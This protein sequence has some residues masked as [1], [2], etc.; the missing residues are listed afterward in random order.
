M[1]NDQKEVNEEKEDMVSVHS[2]KNKEDENCNTARK[3]ADLEEVLVLKENTIDELRKA[4]SNH[5]IE[6]DTLIKQVE[7][8]KQ[9]AT[10][11]YKELKE[12]K[13]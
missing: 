8:I 13:H 10:N 9:I 5:I 11:I 3:I 6:K 12:L 1:E 2:S 7:K 4:E